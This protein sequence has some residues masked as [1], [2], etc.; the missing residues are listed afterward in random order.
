MSQAPTKSMTKTR[1]LRLG[2]RSAGVLLTTNEF[3]RARFVAGWRYEL[4]NEVLV[5]SPIASLNERDPNEELGHSLRTYQESH[6]QGS[7]LDATIGEQTVETKR[8]RRRADRVIWAGLGRLPEPNETPTVIIELVSKGKVN[9]ERDY[10]AKRAE[11][12][13]IGVKEYWI[14]N[15]FSKTLTVCLFAEDRDQEQELVS[16]ADQ[17]YA[18]PLLPGYELPLRRLLELAERRGKS[19]SESPLTVFTRINSMS[20]STPTSNPSVQALFIGPTARQP[21]QPVDQVVAIA[22]HGLEGD[23]KYRRAGKPPS[24]NGPD[25]EITLIEAEAIEAV[26]RDYDVELSPLETRRNVVTR[27]IA[28]NH[29]VGKQF[30]VGAVVLRGIRLCEPCDHLESLTRVG[31]RAALVH[32]GGL[33]RQILDGGAIRIGD[34]IEPIGD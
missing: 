26:S 13:E 6:P 9:H 12:R 23:R 17:T 18:T 24:K 2:P 8:N 32:R 15:R 20:S 7:A 5:V 19:A 3:D 34:P 25:R 27:G 31:V 10:V 4:I 21:L 1:R 29:L 11:Y 16:A 33:R 14:I 30:R 28:L 22:G